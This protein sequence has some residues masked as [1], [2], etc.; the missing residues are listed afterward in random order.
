MRLIA[1]QRDRGGEV[2]DQ[3]AEWGSPSPLV[4]VVVIVHDDA[5]RLPTAVR[6]VLRQTL[7]A[8]EVVIVDDASTD[9]TPQ[10]VE[11]LCASDPRVRAVRLEVNSGG[12]GRP[13]N[14]GVEVSRAPHVM[15]LDSD[16]R[17]ERHACKN[18]LEALEDA[19]AEVS[20]GLVRR[21]DMRTKRQTRWFAPIF[22]ERRVVR[23][24][25]DEPRLIE[26][27][28]SVNKLYRRSFLDSHG[29][30]FPE[31]V[32]YEDQL[33]TL[34]VYHRARRIAIIP[35]VVYYWRIYPPSTRRS[36]TQQRARSDNLQDRLAVHRRMDEYIR[37]HATPEVQRL[38]DVKFL[39]N[40]MSLY[41]GDTIIDKAAS[42]HVLP[43]AEAYLRAIPA[44]RYLTLP[45]PLRAA[46][47]MAFRRDVEGVRQAMLWHNHDVLAL[48]VGRWE[49]TTRVGRHDAPVAPDPH[50][51]VDARENTFLEVDEA[52]LRAPA[53]SYNLLHEVTGVEASRGRAVL[54]VRTADTLGKLAA[55]GTNWSLQ[56]RLA[57]DVPGGHSHRFV[58]VQIDE[59]LPRGLTWSVRIPVS[60][61][62]LIEGRSTWSLA[63]RTRVRAHVRHAPL[64]WGQG[65]PTATAIGGVARV[66]GRSA[67]IG[68][69]P[70]GI[71]EVKL[72]PVP[73]VRRRVDN[74]IRRR[75]LPALRD[76]VGTS[77]AEVQDHR[78]S[79]AAYDLLRRVPLRQDRVVFE[80]NM[81]TIYGDSPKYVYEE[82]R[83]TNPE[84]TAVWVLPPGHES[85]APD[86]P[87]VQRGSVAYLR[88]LAR[89]A[90]WV[91]NQGFPGYA[92]K[93]S[94]QRYL[95]TWHGIPLKRMGRHIPRVNLPAQRP[96]TGVGS[97][98][99]LV[100]PSSYFER[101][102]IDAY[103]YTGALVRG[104]TPRNDRLVDGSLGASE[105]R[106]LL[107]VPDG[108]PVVLYAP[109]F[110]ERSAT[111]RK[112]MAPL[113]DLEEF[114]AGLDPLTVVLLR[115]HYLNA[116]PVPRDLRLRVLDVSSVDDIN[117]VYLAA[118]LL[119][120][121][122]SSV[123]FD[124]ALLDRPIVFH[125]PDLHEYLTLR[126]TYVDLVSVAPGPFT[127]TT[128]ELAAAVRHALDHPDERSV[129]RARF[130]ADFCPDEDGK[131]SA[132]AVAALLESGGG[133]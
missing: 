49:G 30:R 21:L 65:V 131:A 3:S 18:L 28:L 36:I 73:G 95:Q 39:T 13:R 78:P 116:I 62:S 81:G 77:A 126:G 132:R 45:A 60:E 23:G 22:A 111:G 69:G 107:D 48:A 26:E 123:M 64:I 74:R 52:L 127:R 91:D 105:A 101:V 72:D 46:Y 55:A 20:M 50:W 54:R 110:R 47:A 93:R 34:Q 76:R 80:A 59:V 104:G 133:Q 17:L 83:R 67:E 92:R 109:T 84:M 44:D 33:F 56:L 88:E 11:E 14:S 117:T 125:T 90:Y 70:T 66:V 32:H 6:S 51:P 24:L 97:W 75:W 57:C 15:F 35:E 85:P 25:I 58:P 86:V 38:K 4:T 10:V 7:R 96:D 5:G 129:D 79:R 121:D 82:L 99:V 128:A 61:L 40:D 112:R 118:D 16:D 115:P 31:D 27:V 89:A 120:T 19:D 42:E 103:E 87:V 71:P 2:D 100:S 9:S 124:Y 130:V 108:V 102:F 106:A 37:D 114:V 41:L 53:G 43:M 68:P 122:Y 113:F 98:D 1:T 94:G 119:I 63:V 29:I 12:C 8:L